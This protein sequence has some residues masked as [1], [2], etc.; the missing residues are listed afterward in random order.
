MSQ[1]STGEH[2]RILAE[3]YLALTEQADNLRKDLTRR[4]NEL[5]A[6]DKKLDDTR[7]KIGKCVGASVRQRAFLFGERALIV[8]WT[9][10]E[11]ALIEVIELE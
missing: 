9:R 6:L 2:P 1:A 3:R 7:G 4:E 10:E 8:K 5:K 11:K